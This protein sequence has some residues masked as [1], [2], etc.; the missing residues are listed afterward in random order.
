MSR[1][2]SSIV[3]LAATEWHW[4]AGMRFAQTNAV[5][6]RAGTETVEEGSNDVFFKCEH[7][8]TA[9]VVAATAAGAGRSDGAS[10]VPA[11]WI[12]NH[13]PKFLVECTE[14]VRGARPGTAASFD[15]ERI[16]ADRGEGLHQS[17]WD[18]APS[19]ASAAPGSGQAQAGIAGCAWRR[20]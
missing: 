5:H 3:K 7:C 8:G 2:L 6:G 15:R 18:S 13:R 10:T 16:A 19:L 12:S 11:L 17:T 4:H 1:L 20:R 9:L 14:N